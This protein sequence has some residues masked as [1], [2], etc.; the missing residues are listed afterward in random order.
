MKK[1]YFVVLKK[2]CQVRD[3]D[4]VKN[5]Y[6]DITTVSKFRPTLAKLISM[7]YFAL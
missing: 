1:E 7:E 5:R 2:F 6:R 3:I 4:F